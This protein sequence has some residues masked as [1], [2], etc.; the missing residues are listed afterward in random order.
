[1][2]TADR[3]NCG[4]CGL[5]CHSSRECVAGACVCPAGLADCDGD[6]TNGCETDIFQSPDGQ[7]CGRCG[8]LC[9]GAELCAAGRCTCGD[10]E[11]GAGETCCADPD[12]TPRCVALERDVVHCGSCGA[13]CSAN[14]VCVDGNCLQE[15]A[16]D[17]V[18]LGQPCM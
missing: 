6:A 7:N 10:A 2:I 11:C 12:G 17:C 3:A 5:P 13:A 1:D 14:A 8:E 9:D 4:A 15:P 16:A 18:G